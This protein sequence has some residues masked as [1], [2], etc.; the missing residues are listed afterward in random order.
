[1]TH[2]LWDFFAS[3]IHCLLMTLFV[4]LWSENLKTKAAQLYFI[5]WVVYPLHS[6]QTPRRLKPWDKLVLFSSYRNYAY[7]HSSFVKTISTAMQRMDILLHVVNSQQI[8][9]Y[10]FC[11]VQRI[12]RCNTRAF[13]SHA[14]SFLD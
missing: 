6:R 1:M 11:L 8:P 10:S 14:C 12:L 5:S 13:I 9:V 4:L 7:N 2:S 3:L